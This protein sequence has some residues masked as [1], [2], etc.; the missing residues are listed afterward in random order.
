MDE[1]LTETRVATKGGEI[2]AKLAWQG[3]CYTGSVGHTW[4]LVE[5]RAQRSLA[6]VQLRREYLS[7]A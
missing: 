3:S 5:K 7:T 4:G 2:L 1:E 6:K